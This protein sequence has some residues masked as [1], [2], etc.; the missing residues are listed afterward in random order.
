M[1]NN[2]LTGRLPLIIVVLC[3]LGGFAAVAYFSGG[4]QPVPV[5]F[6]DNRRPIDRN[7]PPDDGGNRVAFPEPVESQV[8]GVVPKFAEIPFDGARALADLTRLCE[9]GPRPSGSE[10]M[11]QQQDFLDK[12]FSDNGAT[13]ARQ[14]FPVRHP[15]DGSRVDMVNLVIQWHPEAKERYLIC[16]HYDTRPFPDQDRANP[17]GRF[18]G[19]NDGASGTAV[20]M[21]LGR[22]MKSLTGKNGV[23]FVL[24][25]GEELV[26]TERDEYFLGST[27][28]SRVYRGSPPAYRYR[29]GVLLDMVGDA[30]LQLRQEPNSI[31]LARQVVGDVWGAAARLGVREFE[32]AVGREVR[33]DHLPLNNIAN[34]RT[35]DVIDFDYPY[36]HTEADTPDKCSAASLEKVGKTVYEWLRVSLN[37]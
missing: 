26:F 9:F 37:R 31:R 8:L 1:S 25:D 12:H 32:Q 18:V 22:N 4:T 13:V 29:Q 21:E 15:L 2:P 19:A 36:W 5:D 17:R 24:F 34:I 35:C 3:I 30:N 10:A 27:Y 6:V 14:R 28:F 16:A 20:L 23:D 33:D 11:R 7:I